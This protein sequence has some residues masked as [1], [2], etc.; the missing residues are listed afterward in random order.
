M[1]GFEF[2]FFFLG[3]DFENTESEK[4]YHLAHSDLD[5]L[6]DMLDI[7]FFNCRVCLFVCFIAVCVLI[8]KSKNAKIIKKKKSNKKKV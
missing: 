6:L 2:L 3:L 1:V 5:M 8:F 4:L 7:I